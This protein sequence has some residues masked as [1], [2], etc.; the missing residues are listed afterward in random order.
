MVDRS[1]G[2]QLKIRRKYMETVAKMTK[3]AEM[4]SQKN[5]LGEGTDTDSNTL[6]PIKIWFPALIL[7]SE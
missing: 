2:G 4:I 3:E 1:R 7:S 6:H 5:F